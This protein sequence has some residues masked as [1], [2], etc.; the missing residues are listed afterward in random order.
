MSNVARSGRIICRLSRGGLPTQNIKIEIC[1][2]LPPKD[3]LNN[4]LSQYYELIVQ[5]MRGMGFEI[6]LPA[7]ESALAEF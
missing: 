7:P 1:E 4:I 6:D 5:R 3:E 2:G